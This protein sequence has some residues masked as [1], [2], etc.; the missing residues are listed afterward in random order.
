MDEHEADELA[1]TSDK[2]REML[3]GYRDGKMGASFT[4]QIAHFKV[5]KIDK[6]AATIIFTLQVTQALSNIAG[7]MHGGAVGLIV[8]DMGKF[9]MHKCN[10]IM[11]LVDSGCFAVA[12]M[13][14]DVRFGVTTDISFSCMSAIPK[15]S[16]V[17][18]VAKCLKLGRSM[19]Y[20]VVDIFR[21]DGKLAA[22][23]RHSMFFASS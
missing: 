10:V 16:T 8:D 5:E 14:K 22:Q 6:D 4:D 13:D 23:G 9:L 12:L 2:F 15:D 21:E 20:A 7:T 11:C 18:I 17:R 19:G 3:L 1:K